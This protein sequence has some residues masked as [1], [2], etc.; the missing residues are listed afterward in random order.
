MRSRAR[1]EGTDRNAVAAFGCVAVMLNNAGTMPL[2]PLEQ[3]KIDEWDQMVDVNIKSVFHGIA[4]V[5]PYM[6]DKKSGH[7]INVSSVYPAKP[8]QEGIDDNSN[9]R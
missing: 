6:M 7:F 4:A 1:A 5:L 3:L 2:A 9:T 8:K